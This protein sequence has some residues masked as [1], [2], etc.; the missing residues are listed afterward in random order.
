MLSISDIPNLLEINFYYF[1]HIVR[2]KYLCQYNSSF[3]T[4]I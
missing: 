3:G 4:A 2:I 1:I